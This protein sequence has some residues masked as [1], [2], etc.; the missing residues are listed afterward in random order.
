M[1]WVRRNILPNINIK[2]H[3]I[4]F[5]MEIQKSKMF[6]WKTRMWTESQKLDSIHAYIG[7]YPGYWYNLYKQYLCIR[8]QKSGLSY[9][10]CINSIYAYIGMDPGYW[11]D[12]Y[13]KC[14]CIRW[15]KSGLLIQFVK[16]VII[17]HMLAWIRVIDL[18]CIDSVYA[19][20]GIN[21][22]YWFDLNSH[23]LCIRWHI[24]GLLIWFV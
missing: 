10:N 12:L 8:W 1:K 15:H 11:F 5:E 19:Y 7:M 18:I 3:K 14:L 2:N 9:I 22:G 20:V 4:V 16:T 24:S 23:Y 21:P 17:M 6:K 13:R